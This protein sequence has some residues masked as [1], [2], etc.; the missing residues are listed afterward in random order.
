MSSRS[1]SRTHE[2]EGSRTERD[3]DRQSQPRGWIRAVVIY[4]QNGRG[5]M[6]LRDAETNA[7]YQVVGYATPE[8][9]SAAGRLE[10]GAT[11]EVDVVRVGC[12]ANVWLARRLAAPV[13]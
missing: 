3:T 13:E 12:R 1:D 9:R 5:A 7:T 11:V 6:T 8:L 4:E 10:R 2:A